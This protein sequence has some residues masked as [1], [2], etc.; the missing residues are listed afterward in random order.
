MIAQSRATEEER[1][2]EEV[3]SMI[4]AIVDKRMTKAEAIDF[5]EM[6]RGKLRKLVHFCQD[7][8]YKKVVKKNL[9]SDERPLS[10]NNMDYLREICSLP[11]RVEVQKK[12]KN[13]ETYYTFRRANM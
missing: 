11:Y 7:S 3:C 12:T 5:H 6:V 2:R 10:E 1:L 13:Q 9:I 8:E 4:D